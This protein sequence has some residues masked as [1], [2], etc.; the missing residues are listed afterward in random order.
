MD[1]LSRL[2]EIHVPTLIVVGE[3]DI[4]DVHAHAGAIQAA[5]PS[6]TREIVPGADHLVH[7]EQ[8]ARFNTL[9]RS[10][11]NRSR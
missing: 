1:W 11:L 4:P 3:H 10:F 9:V 8:P 6:S 7:M 5:I 2:G